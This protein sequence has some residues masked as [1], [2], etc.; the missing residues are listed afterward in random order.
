MAN[1]GMDEVVIVANQAVSAEVHGAS[2]EAVR[3][4]EPF[5]L[6]RQRGEEIKWKEILYLEKEPMRSSLTY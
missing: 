1:L 4:P 6:H 2:Q 3:P 5:T